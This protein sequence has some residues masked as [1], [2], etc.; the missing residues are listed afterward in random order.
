MTAELIRI[1]DQYGKS[2][3]EQIRDNLSSTG[4]NATGKTSRSLQY[5]V[6]QQGTK[7]VLRITGKPFMAVVETG[8]RATPEYTKPSTQ[9]VAAIREWLKAKGKSEGSAY[10]IAKSIHQKGTKLHRDG[11]R[12][13][14]I[15]NV[16]NESLIDKISQDLLKEFAEEFLNNV[17]IK[18]F[19][20]ADRNT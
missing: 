4:T 11:G 15:S 14:I 16:V 19:K 5:E 7:A 10:G 1:L 2:T 3:V 18:T 20:D 13:D 9:F 12:K 6:K 8:R 17:V